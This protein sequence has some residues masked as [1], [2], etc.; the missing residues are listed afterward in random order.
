MDHRYF[1]AHITID[2]ITE[3][4][5]KFVERLASVYNFR[6]APLYIM[7]TGEQH[8]SDAFLSARSNSLSTLIGDVKGMVTVLKNNGIGVRRYKI[9]DT[10]ID[11]RLTDEFGLLG[12][13]K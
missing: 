2:P 12:V 5:H 7:K 8:E 6:L 10:L 3:T 4:K 1:E 13:P 11:S 9:E